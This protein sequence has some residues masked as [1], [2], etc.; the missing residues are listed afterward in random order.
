M[1]VLYSGTSVTG[2]NADPHPMPVRLLP[3]ASNC[4]FLIF[5]LSIK[6]RL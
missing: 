2:Y 1:A 5:K 4:V 3:P 6:S